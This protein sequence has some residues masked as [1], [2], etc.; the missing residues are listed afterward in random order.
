[1]AA[2]AQRLATALKRELADNAFREAYE[3]LGEEFELARQV[4]E[5]RQ[6]AGLTQKQ[7]AERAGTSQPAIA[8][9]ESGRYRNVSISFLRRIGG[10]VGAVPRVHFHRTPARRAQRSRRS[11]HATGRRS[12]GAASR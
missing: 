9:L 5:L 8:R 4:I 1:M 7:L 11:T 3:E 10:V 2:R 6:A 12:T